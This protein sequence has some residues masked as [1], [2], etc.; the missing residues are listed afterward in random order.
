MTPAM[1][2]QQGLDL[3]NRVPRRGKSCAKALR[4]GKLGVLVKQKGERC[5]I[6]S[7]QEETGMETGFQK[8]SWA[9]AWS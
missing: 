2:K 4:Q 8:P 6:L 9:V 5:I 1:R 3:G 7:E